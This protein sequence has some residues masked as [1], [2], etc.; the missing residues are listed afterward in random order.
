MNVQFTRRKANNEI[1]SELENTTGAQFRSLLLDIISSLFIY[2]S[3]SAWQAAV[4]VVGCEEGGG[5]GGGL[6]REAR[7]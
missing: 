4:V 5:V 1:N 7:Q 6:L 3:S 2:C